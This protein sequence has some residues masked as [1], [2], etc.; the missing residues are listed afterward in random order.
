MWISIPD[1]SGAVRLTTM[2]GG[3]ALCLDLVDGTN[4]LAFAR[5]GAR[6]GQLWHLVQSGSTTRLSNAAGGPDRCLDVINDGTNN[7]LQLVACGNYSGQL[8]TVGVR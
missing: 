1:A 3:A 7:P 6:P 2:F 4:R 8:W 5:C